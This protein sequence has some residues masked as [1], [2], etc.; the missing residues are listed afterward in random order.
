MQKD[1]SKNKSFAEKLVKKF[2]KQIIFTKPAGKSGTYSFSTGTKTG[3]SANTVTG[4][5][6]KLDFT[7]KEKRN[8]SVREGSQK[9][10]FTT[11]G[12]LEIGMTAEID[13][14]TWEVIKPNPLRPADVTI[15]YFA[16]I[17]N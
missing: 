11:D 5:G 7:E 16:E 17:V 9:L 14:E 3:G 15:I 1:Y 4:Y 13:G 12:I 2:G 6:V 8:S 10:I